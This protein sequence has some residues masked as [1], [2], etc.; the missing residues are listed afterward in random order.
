[1]PRHV[2]QPNTST[3][4]SEAD[5][6]ALKTAKFRFR[7]VR[8]SGWRSNSIVSAQMHSEA[9][10]PITTR[11]S[12]YDLDLRCP[13]LPKTLLEAVE[14]A[15][16]PDG[17][18]FER[19]SAMVQ[20]DP[21]VTAR[22]LRIANSAYYG[23][24]GRIESAH[25]AVLVLGPSSVVGVIMSMSLLELKATLDAST[26]PIFLNLVRHSVAVAY[27]AQRILK[28]DPVDDVVRHA[29]SAQLGEAYTAGVL[30]DFGK[31]VLLYNYRDDAARFYE[32]SFASDE[33]LIG[34]ERERFGHDHVETG[35]FFSQ[36][37]NLPESLTDA[38]AGHHT[39]AAYDSAAESVRRILH[40]VAVANRAANALGY[41]VS[42]KVTFEECRQDAVWERFVQHGSMHYPSVENLQQAVLDA[43]DD[44]SA[45][46]DS[47]V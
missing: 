45:Y 8:Y 47:V 36:Q 42:E 15:N 25:R 31:L 37:L 26:M 38:I 30:H 18:D 13:P 3:A 20:N 46:V 27:L 28:D 39:S 33:D 10:R 4:T 5:A 24:R 16:E 17:P 14:L 2:C 19:V 34:A 43:Q 23:Q 11:S 1:M 35:L 12:L 22:V 29:T 40:S 7:P 9:L 44:L 6:R 41:A 21:G 32:A